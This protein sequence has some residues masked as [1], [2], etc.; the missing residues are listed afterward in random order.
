V[1]ISFILLYVDWAAREF[2]PGLLFNYQS[3][4]YLV[5]VVKSDFYIITTS[6]SSDIG[7]IPQRT[8]VRLKC[9]CAG[10]PVRWGYGRCC[11]RSR[12]TTS[13]WMH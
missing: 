5:D 11:W 3:N 13:M 4:S 10:C 8:F 1:F 9:T 6:T 12:E 2:L 7:M